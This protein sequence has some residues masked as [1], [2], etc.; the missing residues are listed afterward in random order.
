MAFVAHWRR[1]DILVEGSPRRTFHGEQP[2]SWLIG[3]PETI[4]RRGLSLVDK[5]TN[6]ITVAES[7]YTKDAPLRT[8]GVS[9]VADCDR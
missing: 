6:G 8:P 9:E 1:R 4:Q 3:N 7:R 2:K 5:R